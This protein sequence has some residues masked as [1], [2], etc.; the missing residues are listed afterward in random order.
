M[1]DCGRCANCTADQSALASSGET[2]DQHA[3][4]SACTHLDQVLAIVTCALELAFFVDI[5]AR[6]QT[7]VDQGSSQ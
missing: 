7:R 6:S 5:C 3:A 1:S 4:A 2:A